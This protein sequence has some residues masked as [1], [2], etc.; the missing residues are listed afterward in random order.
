MKTTLNIRDSLL[1]E[2]KAL[3]VA[4]VMTE[5]PKSSKVKAA[6]AAKASAA[7]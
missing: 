7:V 5:A 6:K 2:A 4:P 1:A 3:A